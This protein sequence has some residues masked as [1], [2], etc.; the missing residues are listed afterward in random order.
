VRRPGAHRTG[1]QS[2]KGIAM[3][4]VPRALQ[5]HERNVLANHFLALPPLDLNLRFGAA[6]GEYT[7]RD[8]VSRLDFDRDVVFAVLDEH[9]LL[10]GVAHLARGHAFAELGLSVLP[11]HRR[12]GIGSALV[13]ASCLRCNEWGVRE[14]FMRCAATNYPMRNLA[15][16]HGMRVLVEAGDADASLPLPELTPPPQT[17]VLAE[18]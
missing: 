12:L 18:A 6:V 7:I 8:Y 15:Q 3:T 1:Y 17:V 4:P 13:R 11:G 14:L 5:R 9:S 2:L 10:I 16:K